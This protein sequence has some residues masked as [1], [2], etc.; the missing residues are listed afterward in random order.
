M[1]VSKKIINLDDGAYL[2]VKLVIA[3]AKAKREG[4]TLIT[5]LR[6]SAQ[7]MQI[8]KYVSRF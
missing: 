4:K 8:V 3:V 1:V 6:T 7:N 2:A 5:S